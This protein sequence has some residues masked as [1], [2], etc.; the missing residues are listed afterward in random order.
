M[1]NGK[2]LRM[3]RAINNLKMSIEHIFVANKHRLQ[4]TSLGQSQGKISLTFVI[5]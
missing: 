1:S 5:C 2:D 3:T 4:M